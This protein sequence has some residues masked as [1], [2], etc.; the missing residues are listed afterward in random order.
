MSRPM[1]WDDIKTPEAD[2]NVRLMAGSG[3]IPVYWA[4]GH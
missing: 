3:S 1:P 4:K 2:Y